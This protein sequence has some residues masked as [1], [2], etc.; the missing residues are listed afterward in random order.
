MYRNAYPEQFE[1][2]LCDLIFVDEDEVPELIIGKSGY[3]ISMYAYKDGTVHE[4]MDMWA[5]GAGGN[6][7]YEYIPYENIMRNY[8]SDYAGYVLYT[9]YA[10]INE[11]YN[12]EE[13]SYYL[14]MSYEDENGEVIMDED[15]LELDESNWHY[16]YKEREISKEEYNSYIINS[17][18]FEYINGS[19]SYYSFEDYL[20]HLLDETNENNNVIN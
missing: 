9:S 5:Y 10:S 2:L 16:Y 3:W 13:S 14:K 4:L 20:C 8:N 12:F 15:A 19:Q 17:E 11:N 7:G 1:E 6:A 18:N